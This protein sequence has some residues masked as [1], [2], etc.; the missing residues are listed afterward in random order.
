[1]N[2]YSLHEKFNYLKQPYNCQGFSINDYVEY[3]KDGQTHRDILIVSDS[4][5]IIGSRGY[6]QN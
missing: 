6:V 1:M 5:D 3:Q 2:N 4:L